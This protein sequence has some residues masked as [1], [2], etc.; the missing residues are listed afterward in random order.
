MSWRP[1]NGVDRNDAQLPVF[2]VKRVKKFYSAQVRI[3]AAGLGPSPVF[4]GAAAVS[5]VR[6]LPR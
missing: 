4:L 5:L 2:G 1:V 6:A 3:N